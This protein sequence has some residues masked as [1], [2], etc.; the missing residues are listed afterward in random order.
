MP[1]SLVYL[2]NG[3]LAP[4]QLLQVYEYYFGLFLNPN[5]GVS[6]LEYFDIDY[7]FADKQLTVEEGSG[8]A[9]LLSLT[10]DNVNSCGADHIYIPIDIYTQSDL[11]G[12]GT[13]LFEVNI[14]FYINDTSFYAGAGLSMDVNSGKCI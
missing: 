11:F 5:S 4:V 1:L 9:N 2:E 6:Y 7:Y 8:D 14:G 12:I 3:T 10:L 13:Y